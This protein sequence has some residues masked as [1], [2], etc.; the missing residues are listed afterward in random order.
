MP[1]SPGQQSRW[2]RLAGVSAGHLSDI[3][4]GR[5]RPSLRVADDLERASKEAIGR[6]VTCT[7]LL[8]RRSFVF[9]PYVEDLI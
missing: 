6:H 7:A 8:S 2:A 9:F 1:L 4:R 3:I 5:R